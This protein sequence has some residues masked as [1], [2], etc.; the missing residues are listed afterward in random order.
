LKSFCRF[1]EVFFEL[2]Q[3][4]S[5]TGYI[6]A[7]SKL[8]SLTPLYAECGERIYIESLYYAYIDQ[9]DGNKLTAYT[10]LLEIKAFQRDEQMKKYVADIFDDKFMKLI[11]HKNIDTIIL[12]PNN[13]RRAVSFN[14]YIYTSLVEMKLPN[15][16]IYPYTSIIV[17]EFTERKPQ[18]SLRGIYTR[19]DNATKL[20]DCSHITTGSNILLIDDAFGS[21]ATMM[22]IA[23]KIKNNLPDCHIT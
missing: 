15:I 11:H 18:K 1:S 14:E 22:M 19:I 9:I 6:N 21:G 17:N 3:Y 4:I 2:Q 16:H 7:T 8:A 5:S 10:T 23:K 20:F 13:A 12:V